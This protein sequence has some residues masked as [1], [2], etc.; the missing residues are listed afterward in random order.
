MPLQLGEDPNHHWYFFE[1]KEFKPVFLLSQ[2]TIETATK[3]VEVTI[4]MIDFTIQ[5]QLRLHLQFHHTGEPFFRRFV[6]LIRFHEHFASATSAF[7]RHH[8]FPEL[9][10][11]ESDLTV[12]ESLLT[13]PVVNQYT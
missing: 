7:Q 13:G 3:Q 8:D 5:R 1:N 6:T 4:T 12:I 11:T 9:G 10:F 2:W